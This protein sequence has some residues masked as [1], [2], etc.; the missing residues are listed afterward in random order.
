MRIE[1]VSFICSTLPH[2]NDP[3]NMQNMLPAE[4]CR[5]IGGRTS[6]T[7]LHCKEKLAN[8]KQPKSVDFIEMAQ[9]PMMGGGYKILKRELRDRYRMRYETDKRQK[10]DRWGAV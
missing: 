2:E 4:R 1:P 6:I 10:M 3:Q 9:M 5:H 8:F 7:K